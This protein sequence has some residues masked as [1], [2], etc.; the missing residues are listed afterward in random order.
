MVH[1]KKYYI[2]KIKKHFFLGLWYFILNGKIS[3]SNSLFPVCVYIYIYMYI[4]KERERDLYNWLLYVGLEASTMLNL[5]IYSN[6][7]SI[8]LNFFNSNY[9]EN[10]EKLSLPF[11]AYDIYLFN[12][13]PYSTG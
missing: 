13:L 4:Y 2:S 10:S 12:L 1:I 6:R 3:F 11:Q 9:V 7:L 8:Y 5:F